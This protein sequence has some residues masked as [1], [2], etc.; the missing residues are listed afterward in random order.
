MLKA[1]GPA[2]GFAIRRHLRPDR[3][4]QLKAA[5]HAADRVARR[6]GIKREWSDQEREKEKRCPA[7]K[8]PTL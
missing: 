3:A 2:A 7:Q 5:R 1:Q 4:N 6:R 8:S